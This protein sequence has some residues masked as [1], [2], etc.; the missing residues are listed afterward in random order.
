M[1][2]ATWPSADSV[3]AAVLH[4][5][6]Y[7]GDPRG[8]LWLSVH[9]AV[10]LTFHEWLTNQNAVGSETGFLSS[11]NKA[12]RSTKGSHMDICL[13]DTGIWCQVFLIVNAV[14]NLVIMYLVNEMV[15]WR[16]LDGTRPEACD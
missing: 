15:S 6:S 3:T 16:R 11:S 13:P 5:P 10:S 4:F 12:T 7:L 2:T 1:V 8:Q 14:N 9:L